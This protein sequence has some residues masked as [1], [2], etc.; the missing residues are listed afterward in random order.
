MTPNDVKLSHSFAMAADAVKVLRYYQSLL[1]ADTEEEGGTEGGTEAE[2][3]K[4][5]ERRI[6]HIKR[7]IALGDERVCSKSYW[8][9][10]NRCLLAQL[11]LLIM[12]YIYTNTNT[13]IYIYMY[14]NILCICPLCPLFS[15][16][17]S[18]KGPHLFVDTETSER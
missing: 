9:V 17:L 4:E 14:I 3:E 7:L 16:I 10:R 12:H 11:F 18:I 2:E 13:Y 5:E 1:S 8:E 15:Q 6:A